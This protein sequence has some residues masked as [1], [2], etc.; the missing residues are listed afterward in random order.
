VVCDTVVVLGSAT[1]DGATLFGKNSDRD[2][3]EAHHLLRLPAAQHPPQSTV[4]CTY[5]EIPQVERTYEVLLAKPFWIWGAEMGANEHGVT[6]GN[7]AVFTKVPY[8]KDPGMIGMDLLRL[9]LERSSTA[10][11]A[12]EVITSLIATYGQGGNCK[13]SGELYYHNSF[14]IADPGDAW[15][16][17]TAGEHWAAQQVKDIYTISNRIT[18]GGS[19]DLAS[20]DLVNYAVHRGWCKGRDDFDFGRCYSDFLYSTFSAAKKRQRCTLDALRARKGKLTVA[21]VMQALRS[22]GSGAAPNWDPS[23]GLLG[24]TVCAHASFGPVRIDQTTGSM[25]SHLGAD[26]QTHF[27]TATAAPCTSIFKPVWLGGDVPAT[28]PL[29]SDR[30][31]EATLF[32]RHEV[33]HR[34]AMRDYATRMATFRE[35]RDALERQFVSDAW[36][37][38][39]Q[40][41]AQRAAYSAQC[42]AKADE[43]EALWTERVLAT[44]PTKRQGRLHAIAWRAANRAAGMPESGK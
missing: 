22:H 9:G 41:S 44:K 38:R 1:A 14:L 20:D 13:L 6:I 19:W 5:L 10:R 23:R 4:K 25:V 43:L 35:E 26:L 7:E 15:I 40:S 2:P 36:T 31:D 34:A 39:E 42:F 24:M 12:L 21:D 37:H 29:P 32:W 8:D 27:V 17:E 16:L 18:I 3:N 33:L 11:E 30:Y 28:G